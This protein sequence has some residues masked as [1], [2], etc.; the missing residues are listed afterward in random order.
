MFCVGVIPIVAFWP[1]E[2]EE[3]DIDTALSG[4]KDVDEENAWREKR[5]ME[6][7]KGDQPCT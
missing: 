7:N 2:S 5:E 1:D 6:A 4:L 3:P